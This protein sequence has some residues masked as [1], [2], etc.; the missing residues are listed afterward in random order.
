MKILLRLIPVL[1][2]L[3]LAAC[4]SA[5]APDNGLFSGN[6]IKVAEPRSKAPQQQFA[7][8]VQLL[9]YSDARINADAHQIGTSGQIIIGMSGSALRVEPDVATIVGNS[10]QRRLE[11]G[12][13]RLAGADA[14]YELS[15]EIRVFSYNVKA[16]DEVALA[17]EST[18]RERASGKVIWSGLVEDK[19]DRF[20]GVSGNS[21]QDIANY[22]LARLGVVTGK[23]IEAINSTL[24]AS[25]PDLFNLTPGTRPIQGVTV[26]TAPAAATPAASEVQPRP[27]QE[28]M[29][30]ALQL[31][32]KPPRAK[33]YIDE[34][35]YG[36]TPL[37]IELPA[38][39]HSVSVRK[40]PYRSSTEKV[41]VRK[42]ETTEM[43]VELQR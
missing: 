23:T 18:L 28:A 14:M 6:V 7:A 22:L 11:E 32:S 35:Y 24:M 42:G 27:A 8:S 16:R 41:S 34:V 43:E 9:P 39:V 21:K 4:T 36:M 29:P 5:S 13:Y 26:L 1:P 40:A 2:F 25:R 12:G 19:T 20:A 37:R 38:G 15:G 31:S 30:G 3:M 33:V 10:M 17:V